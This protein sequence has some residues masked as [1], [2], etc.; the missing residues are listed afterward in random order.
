MPADYENPRTSSPGTSRTLT[1]RGTI[2]PSLPQTAA[3]GDLII[4]NCNA[5]GQ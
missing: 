3:T 4:T 2:L 5:L 1:Q